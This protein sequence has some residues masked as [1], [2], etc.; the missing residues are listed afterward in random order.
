MVGLS[1]GIGDLTNVML[2]LL[3][4]LLGL[5]GIWMDH[6]NAFSIH[7]FC[8]AKGRHFENRHYKDT[9]IVIYFLTSIL[10]A[11]MPMVQSLVVIP[12]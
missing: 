4:I 1:S 11:S 3:M 5:S 6:L 10:I 9:V 8:F 12:G 7:F 2:L